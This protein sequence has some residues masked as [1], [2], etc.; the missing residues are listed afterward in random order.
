M[1]WMAANGWL[2]LLVGGKGA[3]TGGGRAWAGGARWLRCVGVEGGWGQGPKQ[4]GVGNQVRLT[5]AMV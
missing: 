3:G 4:M 1:R 5:A 2:W